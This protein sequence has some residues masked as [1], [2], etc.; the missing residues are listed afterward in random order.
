[1]WDCWN[2]WRGWNKDRKGRGLFPSDQSVCLGICVCVEKSVCGC[3]CACVCV[4]VCMSLQVWLLNGV[5]SQRSVQS[6]EISPPDVGGLGV[7][8]LGHHRGLW[9]MAAGSLAAVAW[10]RVE[11]PLTG[12]VLL[13]LPW[14]ARMLRLG[15]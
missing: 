10:V 9:I 8:L 6:P 15:V 7:F 12:F 13:A 4:E 1:M 14:R 2:D 5:R 3:V 11:A